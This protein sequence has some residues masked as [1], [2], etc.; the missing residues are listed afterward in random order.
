MILIT[1]ATGT[2]GKE[3]VKQL[4]VAGAQVRALVRH[5]EKA[6]ALKGPGVELVTGDLDQPETLD[7]ALKDVA[8]ALLL[9][10]NTPRQVEQERH[11]IE[12]AKRV[13][14]PH[15]VKYSA[16]GAHVS[17]T[18][19]ISQWHGQ[20]EQYLEAS[21]VPFTHVRPNFFMQNMLWFAS[22]IASQGAFYLPMQDA[23]VSMVDTRDIAA[24]V[25]IVLTTPGHAGKIYTITGPEAL[26]FHVVA[27]K[28]STT[29]GKQ[30]RYGEVSPEH[31]KKTLVEGGQPE[32]YADALNE[33]FQGIREGQYA[34]VTRVVADVA[35][36]PP[37]AF[38][39]FARDYAPVFQ[40][41]GR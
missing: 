1:G 5:P 12:A 2:T 21:G 14:T 41:T 22:A 4:S 31:F 24:V 25:T 19:R 34:V 39:Q 15:V 32:W 20:S 40:G 35:G 38:D 29:L 17:S 23:A 10:A 13:H 37:I 30:V 18:A 3:I 8:C 6:S 36:K 7:A 16:F 28:L 11:F 9:P 27:E 26:S 33:L